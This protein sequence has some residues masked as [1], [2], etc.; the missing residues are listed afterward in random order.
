MDVMQGNNQAGAAESGMFLCQG[1]KRGERLF[2][3]RGLY[4]KGLLLFLY[5]LIALRVMRGELTPCVLEIAH[6]N[7][8]PQDLPDGVIDIST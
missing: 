1:E 8:W 5:F 3:N 6:G 4:R 7:L 2:N